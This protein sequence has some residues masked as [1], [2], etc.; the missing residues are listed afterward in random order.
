MVVLNRDAEQAR[1]LPNLERQAIV[2]TIVLYLFICVALLAVHYL[3]PAQQ[4]VGSSSTSPS[5]S[6]GSEK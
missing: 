1:K 6:S 5:H 2:F 3:Q 4:E